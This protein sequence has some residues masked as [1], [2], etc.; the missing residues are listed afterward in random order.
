MVIQ[1]A[2][3]MARVGGRC[4]SPEVHYAGDI[5]QH[6]FGITAPVPADSVCVLGKG[7]KDLAY[8]QAGAALSK[9]S[10]RRSQPDLACN[11]GRVH[12]KRRPGCRVFAWLGLL[13]PDFPY[14]K[15]PGEGK[16][17][18]EKLSRGADFDV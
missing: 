10:L 13:L 11:A 8:S 12:V 9:L 6:C 1:V 16:N 4:S 17:E 7:Q 2:H 15:V 14:R 5:K 18:A 3:G